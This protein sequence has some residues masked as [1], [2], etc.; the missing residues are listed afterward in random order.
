MSARGTELHEIAALRKAALWSG[1]AGAAQIAIPLFGDQAYPFLFDLLTALGYGLIFPLV[2]VLQVRNAPHRQSGAILGTI[3]GSAVAAVGLAGAANIDVRPASLFVLGMWWWTI[4]KMGVETGT[5]PRRF[6]QLTALLGALGFL[7]VPLETFGPG[8]TAVLPRSV[9][10]A[11]AQPWF[12]AAHVVLGLWLLAIAT[13]F[14]R[15]RTE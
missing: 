3:T 14:A 1:L 7:L 4:G 15:A 12:A 2:A 11:L 9:A 8:F 10:D 13:N 5:L 6:G